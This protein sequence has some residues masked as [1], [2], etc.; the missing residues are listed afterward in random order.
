MRR[1]LFPPIAPGDLSS[2]IN[3]ALHEL[4]L[5]EKFLMRVF[6]ASKGKPKTLKGEWD[7][8]RLGAFEWMWICGKLYLPTDCISVG[9]IRMTHK[10]WVGRAILEGTYVLPMTEKTKVLFR[11][12]LAGR[13]RE[14]KSERS[15]YGPRLLMKMKR[16]RYE[17]A[18]TRRIN[19]RLNHGLGQR[20]RNKLS[21]LF[22]Q[23]ESSSVLI[24]PISTTPTSQEPFVPGLS[25]SVHDKNAKSLESVI[26]S[27]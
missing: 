5:S 23:S 4:G 22:I 9:Y 6:G 18:I 1:P 20:E 17:E 26:R 3:L 21:K 13:R 19:R 15:H 25:R 11:E 8:W 16:Q 14:V 27:R 10:A 2:I 12:Y 7:Y 24:A